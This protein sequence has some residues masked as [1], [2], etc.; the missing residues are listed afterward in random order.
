MP[1]ILLKLAPYRYLT[2]CC[3]VRGN[4]GKLLRPA[5]LQSTLSVP[6][7]VQPVGQD[8]ASDTCKAADNT[9]TKH[10]SSC[11]S[12]CILLVYAVPK[13][14]IKT[15][16]SQCHYVRLTKVSQYIH[17]LKQIRQNTKT[18]RDKADSAEDLYG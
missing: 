4:S 18:K 15:Q 8:W 3:T 14:V 12:I 6:Q 2:L 7:P 1:V 11:K 16:C 5:Y 13:S 9:I 10:S 17:L